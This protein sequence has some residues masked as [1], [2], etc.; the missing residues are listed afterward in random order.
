MFN[1]CFSF[2]LVTKIDLENIMRFQ[3][4]WD[5]YQRYLM[6]PENIRENIHNMDIITAAEIDVQMWMKTMERV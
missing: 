3:I 1:P 4:N 2:F 6:Q 5:L